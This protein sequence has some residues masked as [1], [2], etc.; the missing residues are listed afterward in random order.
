VATQVVEV[1]LNIDM[2]TLYNE[3]APLEAL[4]QRFGGLTVHDGVSS[5]DVYVVREQPEN[6]KYLLFACAALMPH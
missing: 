6:V 1:S 4:L 2:D 3:N 5:A